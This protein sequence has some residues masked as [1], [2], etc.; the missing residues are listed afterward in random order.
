[1]KGK[2]PDLEYDA[3]KYLYNDYIVDN[4]RLKATGFQFQYPDFKESMKQIEKWYWSQ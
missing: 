2:I 4:S 1:M 3:T